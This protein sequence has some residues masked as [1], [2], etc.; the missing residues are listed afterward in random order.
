MFGVFSRGMKSCTREDFKY[1]CLQ[2]LNLKD[3]LSE[4][5]IDMLLDAKLDEK[6]NM[7]QKQ[8]VDIFA[9]AIGEA[10]H[11]AQNQ[12][13]MDRTLMMRYNDVMHQGDASASAGAGYGAGATNGGRTL[14]RSATVEGVTLMDFARK[15]AVNV[16]VRCVLNSSPEQIQREISNFAKYDKI[17][18][19]DLRKVLS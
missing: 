7:D 12:E 6:A 1:C 11:E 10:R 16:L 8:F 9:A 13:A 17:S 5:E 2:R 14:Q 15:D 18:A 19:D 4:K 3:T